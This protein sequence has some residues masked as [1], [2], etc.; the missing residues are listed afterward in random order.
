MPGILLV[1]ISWVSF[2]MA[3]DATPARVAIGTF[4]L[5]E[6]GEGRVFSGVHGEGVSTQLRR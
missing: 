3:P 1:T 6:K 5:K 2:W 4:F